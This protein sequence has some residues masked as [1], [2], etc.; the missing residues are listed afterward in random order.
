LRGRIEA[1]AEVTIVHVHHLHLGVVFTVQV[2]AL[3]TAAVITVV[4]TEMLTAAVA[5]ATNSHY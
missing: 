2:M 3:A 4:L 5:A 1:V